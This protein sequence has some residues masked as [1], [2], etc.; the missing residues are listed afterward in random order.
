[1]IL[2]I[3]YVQNRL[4]TR[5]LQHL[6]YTTEFSTKHQY[7][8]LKGLHQVTLRG[9]TISDPQGC[10]MLAVSEIALRIR[11]LQLLLK[12]AV[13]LPKIH[14]QGVQIHLC[15]EKQAPYNFHLWLKRL[16]GEHTTTPS[17]AIPPIII[18]RIVVQ[19]LDLS[20]DD[21]EA[22][23][24]KDRFDWKHLTLR[25][26][27]TNLAHVTIR[28]KYLKGDILH[29]TG[30]HA[31]LP[32]LLDHFSTSF[33]LS[34]G[35][36]QCQ[37]LNIQTSGSKLKG[38]CT[39]SYN[40]QEPPQAWIEKAYIKVKLDQARLPAQELGIFI[41]YFKKHHTTYQL[42]GQIAGKLSQLALQELQ[43]SFS[44]R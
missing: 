32:C 18:D 34:P 41:P 25:K 8:R 19:N 17:K 39:V 21:Q 44:E 43:L 14:I 24:E 27:H 38:S 23:L 13:V 29:L 40:P 26:I 16:V 4:V 15:K 22:P 11:P 36:L 12:H 37:A 9:L 35:R 33:V 10:P 3:P 20:I 28:G 31:T 42:K 1:M 5:L 30:Q 2:Q 7:F 6:S